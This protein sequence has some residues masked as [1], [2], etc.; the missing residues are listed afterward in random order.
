[1]SMCPAHAHI[2]DCKIQR[3][4][5]L[6]RAADLCRLPSF[7]ERI[8]PMAQD[9]AVS[10]LAPASFPDLAPVAGVEFG[11]TYAGI[12]YKPGRNDLL[13]ALFAEGTTVASVF[14][15]S[16]TAS[17]AVHWCR[18]ASKIAGGE[19]RAL[20]VTAGNSTAGTGAD[21]DRACRAIAEG[22]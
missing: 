12:R 4:P 22:L 8:T 20:I 21:G 16:L 9:L 11:M 17:P 13:V 2:D 7:I 14:T 5:P 18:N 19:A 1:A 10:P 15:K 3:S 6:S